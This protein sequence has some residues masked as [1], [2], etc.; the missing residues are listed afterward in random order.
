MA[1]FSLTLQSVIN[2][3]STHVDL[4]PLAGVG[5]YTN[6]PALSLCNDA[7]SDL[8]AFGNAWKFNSKD[9]GVLVTTPNRQDYIFGG[10]S[11]FTLGANSSGACIGLASSNAI[12]QTGTTTT[13]ITLQPHR[14]KVGDVVF[15]TG[16]SV[17]AYNSVLT[18][19]GISSTWSG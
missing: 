15:M 3:A 11:A 16:N 9:L 18:D 6:E 19:D 17:S 4:L 14:F 7:L 12:T 8:V 10:A 5:G 2:L 13:V 1:N